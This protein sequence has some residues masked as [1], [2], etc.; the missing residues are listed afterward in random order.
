[1]LHHP[2]QLL[3]MVVCVLWRRPDTA[4][5]KLSAPALRVIPGAVHFPPGVTSATDHSPA[6]MFG[7]LQNGFDFLISMSMTRHDVLHYAGHY[8]GCQLTTCEFHG[9]LC[10]RNRRRATGNKGNVERGRGETQR[11]A[12]STGLIAR[13]FAQ[14]NALVRYPVA[15]SGSQ[16]VRQ[17]GS[18]AV[19][20]SG[21]QAVS[22]E[23]PGTGLLA[24]A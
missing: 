4:D 9:S 19:R 5:A 10:P 12:D 23:C 24:S 15:E 22:P 3:R 7:E 8:F 20:Q 6:L 11:L 13:R 2:P 1:M 21:S 16:A 17:S 14:K 18:Q